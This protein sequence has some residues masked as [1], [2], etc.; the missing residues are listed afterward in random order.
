MPGVDDPQRIKD[1]I[2]AESR[3]SLMKIVSPPNPSPV[4]TYPTKEAAEASIAGAPNRR[5]LVY[6]D[7]DVTPPTN[8]AQPELPK[9]FVVVETPS[10]VDGSELRDAAA[11]S[12]TGNDSD[13]QISFS[14][15]NGARNRLVDGK[16]SA[17][18]GGRLELSKSAAYIKCNFSFGE[19]S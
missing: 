4:Q 13:Y 14:Q 11:V 12:R 1:L 19:I 16:T 6:A 7:R 2:K 9:Q 3:L 18:H 5:V 8:P 17:L 15:P 10:V